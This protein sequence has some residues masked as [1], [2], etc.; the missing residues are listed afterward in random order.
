MSEGRLL[1]MAERTVPD[2]ERSAY[3]A[4]LA[5]RR[6]A[7][8]SA[9]VQFW[10]FEHATTPGRFVEFAEARDG[11]RLDLVSDAAAPP[12]SRWRAVEDA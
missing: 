7:Y 8:G 1:Q 12:G 5:A 3:L 6:A 11:S 9:G 4:S 2:T 10:V